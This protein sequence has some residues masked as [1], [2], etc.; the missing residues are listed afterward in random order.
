M[1]SRV[2]QLISGLS[3]RQG[4]AQNVIYA[5]ASSLGINLPEDYID[6][7][8]NSN[9]GEG[10][11]G[12]SYL[13]LWAVED[14]PSLN[15]AYAVN[16]FAPSLVIF[17]SDGG[18]TAYAFDKRIGQIVEVPFVGMA[19]NAVRSIG[20]SLEDLLEYISKKD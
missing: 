8:L 4:N 7:L 1:N 18:G 20:I 13:A 2:K 5:M 19:D 16:E 14:I 15:E 6:F 17:G 9:G 11:I 3:L 10:V 12:N